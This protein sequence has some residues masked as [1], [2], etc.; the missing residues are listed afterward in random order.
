VK[1]RNPLIALGILAGLSTYVYIVEIKGGEKERKE[2]ESRER[3]LPI[4]SGE[5]TGFTLSHVGER[6][7]VE[8][9]AMEWRIQEPKPTEA[10]A[11]AVDRIVRGLEDLKISHD[12]GKQP[13]LAPYHL[14]E[15]AV[16]LEIQATAKTAPPALSLGDEAPT[17][18]GTYARLGDSDKVLVISGASSLQGATFFSLRDKTFLKFDPSRLGAC[19][20]L[21]GNLTRSQGKWSLSAPMKAAADDPSVSDL[22]F[23]LQRLS[24]TEFVT[25][26]PDAGS[27]AAKGLKPPQV[28]VALSGEEWKGEKELS[29]GSVEGGSLYALHPG[30]G[31]VVKVA[32]SIEAKL[33]SSATD[34]RKKDLLPFPYYEITRFKVSGIGSQP[35]ELERKDDKGWM[36]VSPAPGI[37]GQEPVDLLLR[38]ISDLK[39]DEFIDEPGKDLNRYG[40]SPPAIR[41]EIWKKESNKEEPAVLEIGRKDAKGKIPMRDPAWPSILMVPADKWDQ[42]SRQA[43]KVAQ[44]KPLPGPAASPTPPA[45]APK[46]SGG[47]S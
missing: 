34:L 16:H 32:D 14:K 11:E 42:A 43:E 13:D 33:K 24:V 29:F 22:I 47:G 19:R 31:A 39:A 26:S 36:R 23:A 40:L 8:K 6:V 30:T 9:V 46:P 25:E 15:P 44:E 38:N 41:L 1:L 20:I 35:L 28:Q 17:G 12:L 10:D 7:R 2:K 27:L 37:L 5:V 18:G 45:Q 21:R 3:V 4:R